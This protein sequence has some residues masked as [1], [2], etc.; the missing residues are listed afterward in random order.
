MDRT[1]LALDKARK[2]GVGGRPIFSVSP[3][4]TVNANPI[5]IKYQQ[6]RVEPV[7]PDQLRES[8]IFAGMDNEP[9]ADIYR[10]LRTQVLSRLAGEGLTT[11]A[12][13]SANAGDGKTVI[14]ANLAV[15]IAMD[16]N[17]TVLLVDLDLRRPHLAA[18]FGLEPEF[19]IDDY[20]RGEVDLPGCLINPGIDRLVLLPARAP[21][22]K[23][24]EVL[25]SP[26]M[27][28]LAHELKNRYPDR[29]VIYDVPPVLATDDCLAFMPC[30]DAAMFVVAEGETPRTDIERALYLLRDCP[31]VGTVLNKSSQENF[32]AYL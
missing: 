28:S 32:T 17:Q 26:K 16:V 23:T 4:P 15:S 19:G 24:S 14:A 25:A 1:R 13:C 27:I 12:V 8:R 22:D 3:L 11:L 6:T 21:M 18:A 30:I 5:A 29:L 7:S 9:L 2:K 20:L 31:L 10:I